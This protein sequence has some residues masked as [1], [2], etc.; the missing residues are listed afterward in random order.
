MQNFLLLNFCNCVDK[1]ERFSKQD[2]AIFAKENN[3][4]GITAK[5]KN[6]IILELEKFEDTLKETNDKNS[7]A[8]DLEMF[9]DPNESPDR[10]HKRYLNL[11]QALLVFQCK[12]FNIPIP[13]EK[14]KQ[15]LILLLQNNLPQNGKRRVQPIYSST[16]KNFVNLKIK[17]KRFEKANN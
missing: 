2:L 17:S 9:Q 14:T 10:I 3:L 16:L 8:G 4:R 7:D 5:R 12:V 6:D 11:D 13:E 15:N 1:W